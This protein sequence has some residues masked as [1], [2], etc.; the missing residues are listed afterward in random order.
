MDGSLSYLVSIDLRRTLFGVSTCFFFS[1]C[2]IASNAAAQDESDDD[3]VEQKPS[4]GWQLPLSDDTGRITFSSPHVNPIVA[5]DTYVYVVNTPDNTLDV[6]LKETYEIV[7]RIN[8]GIDPVGLA[9]RPGSDEIWVANHI[10][11]SISVVNIDGESPY[12]HQVVATVQTL[13]DESVVT[14]FDEPTGIAFSSDGRK[15]YVTLGPDN[16]VAVVN[17]EQRTLRRYLKVRAQD[18]RAIAVRGWLLYVV[19]FESG[20]T[21]QLSGCNPNDI[22]GRMCTYDAVQETHTTNNVLSLGYD[23][24]IVRN[25]KVPDRDLFVYDTRSD[26]LVD[27]VE[28]VGTLL[29]GVAVDGRRNVFVTQAEA[30]N[31]ANGKAGTEKHGLAEM[32]NR[33]FHNRITKVSCSPLPCH[34]VEFIELE[35]ELP[36]QPEAGQ[37]LATPFAVQVSRDNTTLVATA[38]GSNRLFTV[39]AE[40]GEILGRV[41]VGAVPRGLA[42]DVNSTGAPYTAWV[43]NVVSNTVTVVDLSDVKEPKIVTGIELADPTPELMKQ[44]RIAFNKADAST[45]GTF[46]CESCH[47]DNNVDQL[48]WIL[49]TP[50]CN[51]PGC[52]QIPPRLTMPVRGLR[53]TQPYHWDGIP[54]DPYGGINVESLWESVEPNCSEEEPESCTRF[55]VDGSLA[56]TMCQ[57]GDCPESDDGLKGH[58]SVEDRDAL[59]HYILNVPFP[60]APTRPFTNQLS[61]SAQ[62]GFFE[63]N[64]LNDSG[65]TT[66]SQACGACH[67]PPFLTS[68]NTPSAQNLEADVGSFNGMDA[69]TWRG[70]YDRWIVT[71]QA[72]FNVI[73]LVERIGMDLDGDLPEQEIWF[74]AGARTQANWDMVLEFSTGFPGGYARQVTL[75]QATAIVEDGETMQILSTIEKN[76]ADGAVKLQAEGLLVEEGKVQP[77]ALEYV[78]GAYSTR[79]K[80]PVSEVEGEDDKEAAGEVRVQT[81]SR[82]ELV[83]LAAAGDLVLTITAR[84]GSQVGPEFP[85]PAIWPYW[86][87]GDT[88]YDGVVQ[89]SPTVEIAHL[90]EELTLEFKGRHIQPDANIF[91]NGSRVVGTVGCVEG[92]L[93]VCESETVNITL[94]NEPNRFG[95]NF[96]QI[97]NQ[98]G[99]ISNDMMFFS[100]QSEKTPLG[101]I[102]ENLIVS[103]GEFNRFIFPLYEFWNAVEIDGNQV[104]YSNQHLNVR[105]ATQNTDQPWRAQISHT[106]SVVEGQD[107]ILCYRAKADRNR[108]MSAY[109]DRNMHG[110]QNISGGQF[111]VDLTRSWQDF[112]HEFTAPVSDHTARIAF[113][114]AQSTASVQ[115]DDIGFYEGDRCGDPGI[116]SSVFYPDRDLA[117]N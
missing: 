79:F 63:F 30:R 66:G 97:Q 71:P 45:T 7:V 93:P 92:E 35:P 89:Q 3:S 95:V 26:R 91:I 1:V 80:R 46:S 49:E 6:I 102:G 87:M 110:W 55:L 104:S 75:N 9:L 53:D 29:Y 100:Q 94:E 109:A 98:E 56:T 57:V 10:S 34:S 14:E 33:A 81:F 37:A 44:G 111:T 12:F 112:S 11:D 103:G 38:A 61:E 54:G 105:V 77:L 74:H 48:V 43:L 86:D 83:Q 90:S 106:V 108:T 8:V 24:D 27:V 18:P 96:L 50:L 22:D 15:A 84:L 59:A 73:D 107:Y 114:F 28:G 4:H 41:D 69:P 76:A 19:A 62:M 21:S 40:S 60:P 70:A 20:N 116:T 2:L 52:T 36:D 16:R 31:D 13:Q 51:H 82:D 101:E 32:E 64:Y 78:D 115:I 117:N 5:T 23:V 42:L 85:Q 67:K 72:R 25:P 68:T 58:L 113:D 99:L 47:P 17:A 65:T 88:S 39:D